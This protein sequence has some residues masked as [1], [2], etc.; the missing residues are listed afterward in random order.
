MDHGL[1][2][3]LAGLGIGIAFVLVLAVRLNPVATPSLE[4]SVAPRSGPVVQLTV[5]WSRAHPA[6]HILDVDVRSGG[7][8]VPGGSRYQV[9]GKSEGEL[10]V[11]VSAPEPADIQVSITDVGGSRIRTVERRI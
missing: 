8:K 6:D 10:N 11:T 7:S 9:L 4:V 3:K 5:R 2:A 1:A